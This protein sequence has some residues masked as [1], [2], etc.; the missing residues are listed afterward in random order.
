MPDIDW[1]WD[2][3][4]G[5]AGSTDEQR[6][7]QSAGKASRAGTRA[8][9]M[10]RLIRLIRLIRIVKLYKNAKTASAK[11]SAEYV[12]EENEIHIPAES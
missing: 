8:S 7:V 3:I 12:V 1:I 9:R 2:N 11:K 5:V 4:T 6:Q 10:I